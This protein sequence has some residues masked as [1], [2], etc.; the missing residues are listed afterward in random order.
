M[1]LRLIFGDDNFDW[2]YWLRNFLGGP[3]TLIE[4]ARRQH[5]QEWVD[6][7]IKAA[8]LFT[9]CNAIFEGYS[10][11]AEPDKVPLLGLHKRGGVWVGLAAAKAYDRQQMI[12]E[13]VRRFFTQHPY[14]AAQIRQ[15]ALA[16]NPDFNSVRAEFARILVG[17]P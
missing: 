2:P 15:G 16:W 13:A 4:M 9:D 11:E 1:I 6:L 7:Q 12:D 5:G 8:R 17:E 10:I 3:F 14:R